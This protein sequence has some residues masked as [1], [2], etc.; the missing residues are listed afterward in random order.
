MFKC[1][2]VRMSAPEEDTSSKAIVQFFLTMYKHFLFQ[3]CFK[4]DMHVSS[5]RKC[6]H[7]TS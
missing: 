5:G 4:D 3:I 2:N 1:L 7:L 6:L